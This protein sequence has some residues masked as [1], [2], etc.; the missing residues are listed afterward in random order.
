[1]VKDNVQVSAVVAATDDVP[2]LIPP[3]NSSMEEAEEEDKGKEG[4]V[5]THFLPPLPL[6]HHIPQYHQRG[7]GKDYDY[8]CCEYDN[9]PSYSP[10]YAL[11]SYLGCMCWAISYNQ[12][13]NQKTCK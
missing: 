9:P 7:D 8:D 5:T 13:Q 10:E 11:Y 6:L 12:A 1:M 2:L 4:L 3:S